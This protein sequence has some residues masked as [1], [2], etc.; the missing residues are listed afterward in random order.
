MIRHGLALLNRA[1]AVFAP[2]MPLAPCSPV[3]TFRPDRNSIFCFWSDEMSVEHALD[4][5]Y[6]VPITDYRARLTTG[7]KQLSP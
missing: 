5:S 1:A 7:P 2:A 6:G 4:T 3:I